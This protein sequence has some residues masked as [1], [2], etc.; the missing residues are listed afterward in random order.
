MLRI[1]KFLQLNFFRL[2]YPGT[3]VAY[4]RRSIYDTLSA[5]D[6]IPNAPKIELEPR[7][8]ILA[9]DAVGILENLRLPT[10]GER[11]A[12]FGRTKPLEASVAVPRPS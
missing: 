3:G 11:L 8:R 2:K 10:R 6:R 12:P 5:A 7:H 1:L 9:R 4:S